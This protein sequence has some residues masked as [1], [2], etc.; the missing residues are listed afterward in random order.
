M[1]FGKKV[2]TDIRFGVKKAWGIDSF[3]AGNNDIN[4]K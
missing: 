1:H 4:N 3:E 2:P